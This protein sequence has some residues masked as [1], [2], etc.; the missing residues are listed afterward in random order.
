MRQ[1]EGYVTSWQNQNLTVD[2]NPLH[3]DGEVSALAYSPNYAN[4][5]TL[6]VVASTNGD[7]SAGP[8]DY[9]NKTWLCL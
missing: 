6:L 5:H 4:D 9:R 2:P 8:P 7:V 3:P 1:A